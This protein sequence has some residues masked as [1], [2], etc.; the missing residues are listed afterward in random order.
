MGLTVSHHRAQDE[1]MCNILIYVLFNQNLIKIPS[2]F[3]NYGLRTSRN[4]LQFRQETF[5]N[6]AMPDGYLLICFSTH[7]DGI[8]TKSFPGETPYI[9]N[10]YD[11]LAYFP[12]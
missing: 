12:S 7:H 8:L 4:M 9:Q 6:M 10:P 1:T 2:H 3:I 11:D 5:T